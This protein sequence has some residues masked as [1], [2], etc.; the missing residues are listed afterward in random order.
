MAFPFRRILCPVALDDS[1]MDALEMAADVAR[2]NDGTIFV[3]HVVPMSIEPTDSP[4]YVYLY[5]DQR[6]TARAQLEEIG[7]K[8]LAGLTYQLLAEMGEPADV[9][10]KAEKRERVDLV[11]MGTHGRDGF[12]RLLLGSVAELVLRQSSCPVLAVRHGLRQKH[13]VGAWMTSN[14]VTA[15]PDEMLSSIR[16]KLI[17]G[18]FQFIPIIRGSLLIGIVSEQDIHTHAGYLDHTEASKAM[19]EPLATVH[20]STTLREA[21][22]LLRERGLGTLPVVEEGKLAGLITTTDLLGALA[23]EG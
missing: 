4:V 9:I 7:H 3:L 16:D 13:L 19:R 15:A 1:A 11:V 17:G 14:P 18:P 23:A 8:H 2:Q 22:R 20:P 5:K 21:A 10:L 6:Q 12:A